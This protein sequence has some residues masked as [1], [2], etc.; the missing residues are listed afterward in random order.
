MATIDPTGARRGP[1]VDAASGHPILVSPFHREAALCGTCHD[2]SNPA[3]EKNGDGKYVPNAFDTTA[4]DFSAHTIAPVER[5]YS[6]WF[7]SE[8]NTPAGVYAP[9]FG[10]NKD[11]VATCQDCHM[12]D[13]T[14]QGCNFGSPPTRDD[15]PLH[16]ITG[17]STWFP[18]LLSTL[19]PGQ[20][21]DAAL[22]AGITRA[23]YMLRNA[24][25]LAAVQEGRGLKV[26][27]TNNSGH[28]LPTGYPEG[29]RISINVKF[30]D[31]AMA[32][33][34]E[35][36]AYDPTTGVL[37][38]DAEAKIYDIEPG[39]DEVTAP[40]VG[41]A[42]GPSFH[43]ALNNAV[44]KDNRIP[45][46]GFTNAAYAEFGG[47]HVAYSYPDGQYWDDTYYSIPANAS[48]VEVTLYYQSTSKEFVEFLRDENTTNAKGHELYDLW[49][50]NGKSP[51]EVMGQIQLALAPP[52]PGDY[53]GDGDVDLDDYANFPDCLTGPGGGIL[54][55][56]DPFDLDAD[57][58]V[59]LQ[60]FGGF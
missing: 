12:R 51:P 44:F 34:S 46:R 31:A 5:T 17:G 43:F 60:D 28:K 54:P 1:F 15:L 9:Q 24:A 13:V 3:F 26:T 22:Q 27:V 40:L 36:G 52:V 11:Y 50:S 49:N 41:V 14:G 42:P 21:N 59:D 30:Y 4:S 35:S 16:D 57:G 23:R 47:G 6:E 58:D 18:G 45:P 48:S 55:D 39:L 29:R 10:G 8:Y 37:S 19:Y 2:V 56:C 20:V 7:Y 32:L 25:E 53:D 33:I 38:H